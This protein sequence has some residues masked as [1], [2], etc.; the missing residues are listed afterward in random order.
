M[1][2][3]LLFLESKT[4]F[5]KIGSKISEISTLQRYKKEYTITECNL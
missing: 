2:I 4:S 3:A 1:Q 5:T